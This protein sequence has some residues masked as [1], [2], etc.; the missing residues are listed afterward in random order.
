RAGARLAEVQPS[1]GGSNL[2][3]ALLDAR[4]LLGGEAGEV[5]VFTDEAGPFIVDQAAEEIGALIASG[6]SVIPRVVRADPA[7]N[8]SVIDASYQDGAGGGQVTVRI[9]NHGL[10]SVEVACEVHL[11]DGQVIPIFADLPPMGEAEERITVPSEVSGG[12][13]EAWCDDPDLPLDDTRY[14]HLPRVGA[15]RILVVDGDPGDTPTRSEVY[16]LERALSPWGGSRSGVTLDVTTPASLAKPDPDE[17]RVV[18][19]ANVSDPRP[20]GLA[21]T[22]FVRQGGNLIITAG[23]NLTAERYNAAFGSMLPASFRRPRSV[24]DAGEEGVALV[25]PDAQAPLFASFSRGGRRGFSRV[26]AHTLLT[27]DPYE[28]VEDEITTWLKF[29][30]GMPALVE[31]R[32]GAGRVMIWTS[33]V[34]LGWGNLPLQ[35]IFMPMVQR[36]VGWLGAESGG[37]AIRLT[38]VVGEPVSVPLPDLTIDPQVIGPDGGAV[39]SHREGS[40]LRFQPKRPGAYRIAVADAPP[41]AWVAVNTDPEESRVQPVST[42]VGIER[43]IAPELLERQVDLGRGVFG[44]VLLL[45]LLQGLLSLRGGSA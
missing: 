11:P 26:K 1:S 17:H 33:S 39:R 10:K 9:A 25:R 32:I 14:F 43:E 12:V 40:S 21:L 44:L 29:E 42:I 18:I 4:R 45:L 8:V 36:M 2:R 19:L 38:S 34:D 35:A 31:R 28:D 15:S 30:N 5:L 13:G 22:E 7:R 6:S 16:F 24:A 37:N 23:S 41:L 20:F 3:A 27:L